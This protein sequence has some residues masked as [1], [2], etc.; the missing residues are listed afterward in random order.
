MNGIIALI[1]EAPESSLTS[2]HENTARGWP[3]KNQ[4]LGFHQTSNLLIPLSWTSQPLEL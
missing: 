1:K 3:S 4:E 2:S